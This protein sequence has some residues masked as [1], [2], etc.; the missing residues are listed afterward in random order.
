MVLRKQFHLNP[1]DIARQTIRIEAQ[2]LNDLLLSLDEKFTQ[3]I[4]H[5]SNCSGRVVVTG[6]GK[7]ALVG[8]KMVA[9]LNSTGTQA[10]FMHAADAVHG[11]L[12]MIADQDL[13]ICISKSG[14]TSELKVL[15]P[16]LKSYGVCILAMT[17][18]EN[19]YLAQEANGLLYTPV[20]EE[21]DPNKLAPTSSTIVQSAMGDAIA[22]VLL[23]KKGF[24]PE[25]FAKY[26]PGGS[27]GKQLYLRVS[28]LYKNNAAPSVREEVEVKQ[29]L[30][31]ISKNL[32]GATVV[33]NKE[34]KIQGIITDGDILRWFQRDDYEEGAIAKNIMSSSP[35]VI[36]YDSLAINAFNMMRDLQISQLPVVNIDRYVGMIHL[37]DLLKEGFV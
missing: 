28:D 4:D 11:D 6:I 24:T 25:H 22:T 5:L 23:S 26:H 20:A 34:E 3:C 33:I 9:T 32:L 13:V 7:S 37:N 18:N 21:A 35:N 1:L 36:A 17:S 29:I 15:L 27:L 8:Q 2:A 14:E 12:G 10:L 16:I 31:N 30:L 19:S